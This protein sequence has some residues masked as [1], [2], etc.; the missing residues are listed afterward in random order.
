VTRPIRVLYLVADVSRMAGANRSLLELV[1]S[2]P[3]ERVQPMVVATGDGPVAQAYRDAGVACTVLRTGDRL[4]STDGA[5]LRASPLARA[6]IALGELLPFTRQLWRLLRDQKID[7]VHVNDA[8]GAGIVAA[9]ARLAGVPVVGH[10][11]GELRHEGMARW[12]AE[13]VP[14]RIIAVSEGA[15]LTLSPRA[16]ARAVTVYNG[17]AEAPPRTTPIPY[18]QS[19]RDRGVRIVC[20]FATLVPFKGHHHL[21]EAVALLN[22]RGW[23]DR[24]AVVC[25]GDITPRGGSYYDWIVRSARRLEVDNA[26]FTGWHDVPFSF[27]PYA[28]VC[29][30]PSVSAE[31]LEM[32]GERVEVRGSE[33]F[34]RTH[35]EAMRFGVP[36][37]GTRIA[38][39]PEQ[40][41]H[42][43]T[44]LV[45]EPGDPAAL[46]DAL[47]QLLASP[48][49]AR[50]MG[51]A[52]IER[53]DRLFST[54]A[55]VDGVLRVYSDILG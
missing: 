48:E 23:R 44:G 1:R 53:V 25:I 52:G 15:R 11:R 2:L 46:A 22:R 6:R 28:D 24:M 4:N 29:V 43:V 19:L 33:G 37:V 3:P 45:V 10:L 40:V 51:R 50:R 35:L 39:V 26:T 18:L 49:R 21:L 17:I 32:D 20:C 31:V 34:P 27:Y 30:L 38:G 16:Q 9:A 5:L 42:G 36:V 47:E 41:E 12:V 8:R 7:L 14:A 55:Y 13:N 54:R